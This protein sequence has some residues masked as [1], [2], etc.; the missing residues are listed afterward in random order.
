MMILAALIALGVFAMLTAFPNDEHGP[1]S[2]HEPHKKPVDLFTIWE[3]RDSDWQLV[4][5]ESLLEGDPGP[6]P[7][8][9][10]SYH[11]ERVKTASRRTRPAGQLR[12]EPSGGATHQPMFHEPT[13][14]GHV[15]PC[16]PFH[17]KGPIPGAAAVWEWQHSAWQLVSENIPAG[18]DP[19]P[20]PGRS[21]TYHGE[22][23]KTW[24]TKRS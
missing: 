8:H 24:F 21:G 6:P 17:E 18:V 2:T 4:L 13:C 19:G 23:V 9:R 22:R 20:P 7:A 15:P 3:W 11:G 12:H 16:N 14:S 10:G 1:R 5:E